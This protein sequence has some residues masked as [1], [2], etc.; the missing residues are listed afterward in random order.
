MR[1]WLLVSCLIVVGCGDNIRPAVPGDAIAG[2]DGAPPP[3]ADNAVCGDGIV[4]GSETCDDALGGACCQNCQLLPFN[5]ICRDAVSECDAAEVCDG[6]VDSCPADTA[7]PNGTPCL[8]GFCT[9]GT[10]AGCDASIDADFDGSNQCLDCDDNNGSVRPGKVEICDGVDQ[11]CDGKIDE[12]FDM[13]GDGFSTCSEDPLVRD[14]DDSRVNVHPGAPERCGAAGTGNGIDDNCNGFVDETCNPCDPTDNDGDGKSECQGDCDDTNPNVSPGLPEACDGVD[15]DCN[16]FTTKN[17]DV[18]DPCNFT[19]GADVCKDD[20][21]CGC[22]VGTSGQC[23]GD[24]RCASFCEGSFTGAVGAGCTATQTCR[25]RWTLSDNQHACAETTATLGNRLAGE[26]CTTNEQCRSGTCDNYC[27]GPGCT[28]KRC[29]DFCDHDEV[30]A[31]GSCGP[32]AI[33]EVQQSASPT[34]AAMFAS[35]RLDDNGTKTTGQSCT[36]GCKWGPASCVNNVCAEPCGDESHCPVG[37]HCSLR[38]NQQRVGTWDANEPQ[39][40]AGQPAVETVPV[41]LADSAGAHDRPTGAA[42]TT[43]G[44]CESEFCEATLKIC[45]QPCVTDASCSIGMTCD[46]VFVRTPPTAGSGVVWSRMCI[47]PSFPLLIRSL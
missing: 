40:V 23:T 41:C 39:G 10:C 33:C 30:G 42:C 32:G 34:G 38:G 9:D 12:T 18:S 25:F 26:V 35:C 31:A 6:L 11:D 46:P 28:T 16:K 4:S 27:T 5:T 43:N 1:A 14:C 24:F 29:V 13:D 15:T 36:G 22:V 20:A 21:V 8:G 44:D 17:C 45:S 2:D 47:T 3:D 7:M 19:G 37:F